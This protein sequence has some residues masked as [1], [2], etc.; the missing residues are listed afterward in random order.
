MFLFSSIAYAICECFGKNQFYVYEN[1]I[2]SINLPG[3]GDVINARASRTTH[4]KTIG[5]VKKFLSFFDSNFNVITPYCTKTKEDVFKVFEN[6]DRKEMLSSAVSCSATRNRPGLTNHCGCCSQ[7]IERRFAAYAAGL[8]EF[9]APYSSDFITNIPN[10]ET[11]QR[12]Y[13]TL[14]LASAEKIKSAPDLYTNHPDEMTDAIEYWRCDNPE[15][16]LEEIYSLFSRAG[17]SVLRAAQSM[18]IKHDDLSVPTIDNSFLSMLSSRDYLKTPISIRVS[19]I[20]KILN[21]SI[22]Q[23]FSVNKPKD[24]NDLN[25]KIKAIL[26]ASGDSFT[27]EFPVLKFGIT[28]YRADLAE[29]NLIIESKFLRKKTTPSVATEGISA[30]ITKVQAGYGLFFVVYDPERKIIND[31]IFIS[32]F[33]SKREDCFVRVYR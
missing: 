22:P 32:E 2:T 12:L 6:Y 10:D 5:L 15:D 33:Q 14:R 8:E 20:D 16:S 25:N 13:Y 4:P 18:R 1:G 28:S 9:D 23:M 3:Q 21:T 19:E 7:C 17:D 29:D 27:R 26:D 31:D 30:D 11:R 24:E